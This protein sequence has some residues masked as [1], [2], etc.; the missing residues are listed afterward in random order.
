MYTIIESSSG[1]G[2]VLNG[3]APRTKSDQYELVR[4]GEKIGIREV[5]S[6]EYVAAPRHYSEWNSG[7]YGSVELALDALELLTQPVG[8]SG[9]GSADSVAGTYS[10]EIITTVKTFNKDEIN[11]LS[12][13]II[14]GTAVVNIGGNDVTYPIANGITGIEDLVNTNGLGVITITPATDSSVLLVYKSI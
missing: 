10:Q 11:T 12:F 13:Q 3:A 4:Q 6:N 14:T 9:G 5:V 2:F 8:G 7:A 1:N